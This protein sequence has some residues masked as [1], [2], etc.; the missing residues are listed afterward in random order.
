MKE[1]VFPTPP[2]VDSFPEISQAEETRWVVLQG[3]RK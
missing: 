1:Y 3:P 2:V